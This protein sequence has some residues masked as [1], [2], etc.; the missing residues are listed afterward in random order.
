ML[1]DWFLLIHMFFLKNDDLVKNKTSAIQ[2]FERL[3]LDAIYNGGKIQ[4]LYLKSLVA[5]GINPREHDIRFVEDNW[6]NPSLGC[7]G[8]G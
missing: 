7:A 8:L 4:E 6:E 1:E 5:L 3:I 2:G